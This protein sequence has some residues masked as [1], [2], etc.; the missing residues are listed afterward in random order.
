MSQ[1]AKD[2]KRYLKAERWAWLFCY[3]T[4]VIH[5]QF[6]GL[7]AKYLQPHEHLRNLTAAQRVTFCL[8]VQ[9]AEAAE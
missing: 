7:W 9:E 5:G 4:G 6:G 1:I 3:D 2:P 8:F